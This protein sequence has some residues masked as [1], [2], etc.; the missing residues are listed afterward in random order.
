MTRIYFV[1]LWFLWSFPLLVKARVETESVSADRNQVEIDP[2]GEL[3]VAEMLHSCEQYIAR[4]FHNDLFTAKIHRNG[5][6][7]S[8]GE[9]TVSLK[10]LHQAAARL[11][12][13]S[14]AEID[15]Y[16]VESILTQVLANALGEKCSNA[17]GYETPATGFLGH[18]DWGPEHTVVQLDHQTLVPVPPYNTL[19][20]RF[21]TR[22]GLRISSFQQ[23][24]EL[25]ENSSTLHLYAAPAGRVFMFA[26]SHVGEVFELHH[27]KDS[28]G[29]SLALEVLSMDPRLFDIR[30]FFSEEEAQALIDKALAETSASHKLHRSTTGT[31]GGSVFEKRTSEN[32]WDTHGKL[33]QEIKR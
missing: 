6:N 10:S 9:A 24:S 4:L 28:M 7:K 29:Q 30:N 2:S 23:L 15:K 33:A 20:C 8:C 21:Y 13:C 25:L 3:R 16:H 32:A 11:G 14:N 17:E 5:E 26:P 19:P 22:E 31:V 18:C 27:V 12:D 1:T